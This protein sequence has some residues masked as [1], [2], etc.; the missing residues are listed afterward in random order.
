M[1]VLNLMNVEK[2]I[3]ENKNIL[4]KIPELQPYVEQWKLAKQH[5]FLR[6]F[7]KQAVIDFLGSLN[8]NH[9]KIISDYFQTTVT[10]DK[11]NNRIVKNDQIFLEDLQIE[12]ENFE[13]FSNI[14]ISRDSGQCYISG[15]R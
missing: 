13:E 4:S 5:S 3:F 9:L 2:I 12:L 7:G 10:I 8:E 15:W 14:A 1:I 6:S 11:L